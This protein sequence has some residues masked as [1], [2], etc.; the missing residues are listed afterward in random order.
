MIR[1][2]A[3]VMRMGFVLGGR[4]VLGKDNFRV[5]WVFSDP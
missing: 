4:N 1:L 3:V 5:F 2:A